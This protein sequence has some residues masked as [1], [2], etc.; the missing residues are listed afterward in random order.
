MKAIRP[1][2]ALL[3]LL[4]L[5]AYGQ[6]V[7]NPDFIANE[8]TVPGDHFGQSVAV[9]GDYAVIGM[10]DYDN[11]KG[12]AFVYKFE[13]GNWD[14]VAILQPSVEQINSKFGFSVSISQNYIAVGAPYYNNGSNAKVGA[15]FVYYSS[16]GNWSGMLTASALYPYFQEDREYFGYSLSITT[17]LVIGA[18]GKENGKGAVYIYNP[19]SGNNWDFL[20]LLT[21]DT[22]QQGDSLGTSVDVWL[23]NTIITGAPGV[24]SGTG[25]A[26][27]YQISGSWTSTGT[28]SAQLVP[29]KINTGDHFG[30]SVAIDSFAVV[31]ADKGDAS[32]ENEGMA[33]VFERPETGWLGQINE[34]FVLYANNYSGTNQSLA[35]GRSVD[36]YEAKIIAG[37]PGENNGTGAVYLFTPPYNNI[38]ISEKAIFKNNE[39]NGHFGQSVAFGQK[40]IIVGA[41]ITNNI[42]LAY[43]FIGPYKIFDPSSLSDLCGND[44]ISM[45]AY[46]VLVS[47]YQWFYKKQSETDF[48]QTTDN[49]NFSG[50]GTQRL[51]IALDHTFQNCNI[52][53]HLINYYSGTN[54]GVNTDTA[55][56]GL[57]TTPPTITVNNTYHHYYLNNGGV[58]K[59]HF[60]DYATVSDNCDIADTVFLI[61]LNPRIKIDYA[62]CDD[63]NKIKKFWLSATDVSGNSTH[64]MDQYSYEAHDTISPTFD[65]SED[66]LYLDNNGHASL[67]PDAIIRNVHDN[68]GVTD[69]IFSQSEFTCQDIGDDT[70]TVTVTDLAGNYVSKKTII[71]VNDYVWPTL[72]LKS[73]TVDVYLD[74]N[75]IAV[76]YPLI[77]TAYDNCTIVD[78][79][80]DTLTCMAL[81]KTVT[82]NIT[83]KDEFGLETK[84]QATVHVKDTIKPYIKTRSVNIYLDSTGVDT[85]HPYMVID[86]LWDNCTV[87]DTF[88]GSHEQIIV[89]CGTTNGTHVG[90]LNAVDD[91]G[92]QTSSVFFYFTYDTLKPILTCPQDQGKQ[93]DASGFYTV[94]DSTLDASAY[95]NCGIK[96]LFNRINDSTTLKDYAFAPGDYEIVWIAEDPSG[97][98]DSCSFHLIVTGNSTGI[99]SVE[100]DV[101]IY[102]NPAKNALFI[103][104][105]EPAMGQITVFDDLGREV[106]SKKFN[107]SK[108]RLNINDY[109]QGLYTLKIKLPDKTLQRKFI[110]Q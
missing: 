34:S 87:V 39:N 45:N 59:L 25:A 108:I 36:I 28:P 56:I 29:G 75:G 93:V 64:T 44:T 103:V 32:G 61:G 102:P 72:T 16:D 81:N 98:R 107:S 94:T 41:P 95:D 68:C 78:T 66:E 110:K 54:T 22:G 47:Q 18:P 77:D 92:N 80:A 69:T 37:A 57:E 90:M 58:A 109:P 31:G 53:C 50:S 85:L 27:I 43:L 8:G 71:H 35:F 6:Q 51:T 1:F 55:V 74:S 105:N 60:S 73:G 67:N 52:F 49:S 46:G 12:R 26:Y 86:S 97:N 38:T 17:I 88:F 33:Y 23:A 3:I 76:P 62:T 10:P 84:K 19:I 96:R 91:A 99:H 4:P 14:R 30:V 9:Y 104:F 42:G 48:T 100:R 20:A 101:K 82:V 2:V 89:N 106:Y 63:L 15:V 83:V 13:N 11:G 40:Q 21:N 7:Y 70:I 24:N 65:V 79:L 5:F